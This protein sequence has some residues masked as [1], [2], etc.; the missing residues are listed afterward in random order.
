[1]EGALRA[2]WGYPDGFRVTEIGHNQFHFF[3]DREWDAMRIEKGSPWLFKDYALH[4]QRWK[5]GAKVDEQ[6][7]SII[8]IWAQFWGA[9]EA[10]K[11]VEVAH[12]LGGGLGKVIDAGFFYVKGRETRILKAKV[13]IRGEQTIRDSLSVIGP[14]KNKVEVVVRYERLGTICIDGFSG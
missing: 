13:E 6:R 8:P 12:K 9:P 1:M 11:T 5:E 3:F 2:I 7:I 14:D 10:F 4:V